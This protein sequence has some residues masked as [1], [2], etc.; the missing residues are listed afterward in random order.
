M[1]HPQACMLSPGA[2]GRSSVP[3][4]PQS[5]GIRNV[6]VTVFQASLCPTP[7]H[8]HTHTHTPQKHSRDVASPAEPLSLTRGQLHF[9]PGKESGEGRTVASR[10][11]KGS[12]RPLQGRSPGSPHGPQHWAAQPLLGRGRRS[13]PWTMRGSPLPGP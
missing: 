10:E 5:P 12:R 6:A 4:I 3:R 9:Q 8:T 7:L 13:R 2:C 1:G 11:E